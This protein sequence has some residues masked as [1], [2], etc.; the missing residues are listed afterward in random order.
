MVTG[1]LILVGGFAL[2]T[3]TLVAV[4]V[5]PGRA[6]MASPLQFRR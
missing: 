1:F 5:V 4:G 3:T 6:F 2:F